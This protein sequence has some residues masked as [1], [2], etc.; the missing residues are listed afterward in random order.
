M[1]NW[2]TLIFTTSLAASLLTTTTI[3]SA[4]TVKIYDANSSATQIVPKK[5]LNYQY[6]T[7]GS[8]TQFLMTHLQYKSY[9]QSYAVSKDEKTV[10][11]SFKKSIMNSKHVQGSTGGQIF[12]DRIAMTFFKNMPKLTKLQLRIEGKSVSL[13]HVNFSGTLTRQQYR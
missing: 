12:T 10:V 1:K 5:T 3:A 11:L 13:D 9:V 2:K 4:D 6:A 8:L 7:Q